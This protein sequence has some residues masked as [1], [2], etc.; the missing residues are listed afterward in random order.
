MPAVIVGEDTDLLVLIIGLSDR[1][2]NIHMLMPANKDRPARVYS[3][4]QLQSS[5]GSM[6]DYILFYHAFYDYI[7]F[8]P[9]SSSMAENPSCGHFDFFVTCVAHI[10]LCDI[11]KESIWRAL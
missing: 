9:S 7:L 2:T 10:G 5:L 1:N 3:S 8:Y 6:S 11:P 4:K